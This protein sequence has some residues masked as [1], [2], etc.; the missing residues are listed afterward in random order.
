[1][2]KPCVGPRHL[3]LDYFDL[4]REA[5]NSSM[6]I[7]DGKVIRLA[8]LADFAT[9]SFAPVLKSLFARRGFE[10][11]LYEA[12]FDSIELEAA[13]P[14]SSLYKFTPDYIAVLMTT[15]QLKASI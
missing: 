1:M 14:D 5:N 11:Q 6:T 9:Q 8:I 2:T 3:C 12:G 4:V 13:D 7:V 10:L 15:Q